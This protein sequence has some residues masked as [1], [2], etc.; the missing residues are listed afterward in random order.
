MDHEDAVEKLRGV[1]KPVEDADAGAAVAILLKREE[2]GLQVLLVKRA[3]NPSD[4]WSGHMAFPGGRRRPE[5]RDL[6][7]TVIRETREET[8]IELRGCRFLGTL[9]VTTSSVAP[10]LGV[11]PFV[12]LCNETPRITLNEELCSHFWV[13]LEHLRR[14]RGSALIQGVEV[15]AFLVN[16]EVVWG[17]TYRMLENLLGLLEAAGEPP[18]D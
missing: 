10:E 15:P 9:S 18:S 2:R 5:D 16:G 6:R 8:G 7:E 12:V 14:S 13:S 1:L 11:L 3:T 4:P 17:L